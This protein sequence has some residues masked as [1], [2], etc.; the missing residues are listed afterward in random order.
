[1]RV[2]KCIYTLVLCLAVKNNKR[3]IS[4]I[5]SSQN[6]KR[7]IYFVY[8][9]VFGV[10]SSVKSPIYMNIKLHITSKLLKVYFFL[11]GMF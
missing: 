11:F 1:M 8:K 3:R 4:K 7:G 10:L 2:Y 9:P 5:S 6:G